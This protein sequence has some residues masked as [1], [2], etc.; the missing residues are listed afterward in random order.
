M[1]YTLSSFD[2][3]YHDYLILSP[4]YALYLCSIYHQCSWIIKAFFIITCLIVQLCLFEYIWLTTNIYFP[5]IHPL[6]HYTTFTLIIFHS[7][8]LVISSYIREWLEKI[9]F[10][11]LKQID[12]ERL[13]IIR[14]RDELIKQTSLYLPLR[15]IDYYLRSDSDLALSQHYHIKYDR[16]ALL[17]INFLS[18]NIEHE[19]LL[20][21]YINDIEYLLK[22][23]ENYI[24]I[25]MHKKSTIK[26][27]MFSIDINTDDSIKNLQQLIELLFHIDERLKQISSSTIN[28]AAC[29]HIGCVHEILI[30]F[31]KYPK[32]DLWSENITLLQLLIS[33][34]QVNHC[35]TTAPIYHLLNDLYLFRTAGSIVSTQINTANNTNIYYLLGRLIGDNV[36]QGRNA[37]PLTIGHT[38][39]GTVQKS[40]STDDSHHSQSSELHCKLNSQKEQNHTQASTTTTTTSSSIVLNEQQT[41]L[42]QSSSSSSARKHVRI[43]NHLSSIENPSYRQTLLQ[44]LNATTKNNTNNNN[45]QH[46]ISPIKKLSNRLITKKNTPSPIPKEFYV[47]RMTHLSDNSCWSSREAMI[48]SETSG[49]KCLILTQ[50]ML[51][52]STDDNSRCKSTP[53]PP[54]SARISASNRHL[55]IE[56]KSFTEEDFRQLLQEQ[57]TKDANNASRSLS[58]TNEETTSS[59]SGWDDIPSSPLPSIKSNHVNVQQKQEESIKPTSSPLVDCYYPRRPCDLS[60][61]VNM[62]TIEDDNSSRTDAK[63]TIIASPSST[64]VTIT[65]PQPPPPPPPPPLPPTQ[66][67][68]PVSIAKPT[69]ITSPSQQQIPRYRPA[70]FNLARKLIAETSESALSEISVEYHHEPWTQNIVYQSKDPQRT[71]LSSSYSNLHDFLQTNDSSK[72]R[73][74][75]IQSPTIIHSDL[76]QRWLEDQLNLFR[77][78]VK[79]TPPLSTKKNNRFSNNIVMKNDSTDDESDTVS[80]H[81][82][83]ALTNQSNSQSKPVSSNKRPYNH[84]RYKPLRKNSTPASNLIRHES[85]KYR[86]RPL[87]FENNPRLNKTSYNYQSNHI[88]KPPH[89]TDSSSMP[90]SDLSDISSSR[91]DNLSES[92]ISNLESEYDN[93]YTQPINLNTTTTIM[94]NSQILS[95]DDDD[96][97]TLAT[98]ITTNN[99]CYF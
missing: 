67:T 88:K 47:P 42:K 82:F 84:V 29:L 98:T 80:E 34:T 32:I 65:S 66:P 89:R 21:N 46:Q 16:M 55:S 86:N 6:H 23:N 27:I 26:E 5:S 43:S 13:I 40:S 49:S 37:L 14:Q 74:K 63:S 39:V 95:D 92:V 69:V 57:S 18:L 61:T 2:R 60:F 31:E 87:S 45:T 93:I 70:P 71:R 28:L 53:P 7:F 20:I 50:Q 17:Y 36:F 52:G 10:V 19:Y 3:Q 64:V 22:N 91:P 1:N 30:H 15:V 75:Q 35:I 85:L 90:R 54:S 83:T 4:I 72:Y 25:V 51:N 33:K 24:D 12:N 68:L 8:L 9:D 79:Q 48:Q 58:I 11:W 96:E 97:T 44:A 94:T 56:R 78:Q 38:N 76:L 73:P 77:Y 59:F 41:L 81:T 62:T 99:R